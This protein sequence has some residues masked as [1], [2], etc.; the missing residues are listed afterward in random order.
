M[1]SHLNQDRYLHT[2]C[3]ATL[4]NMAARFTELHPYVCQRLVGMLGQLC[5]KLTRIK[6]RTAEIQAALQSHAEKA[7]QAPPASASAAGTA[8]ADGPDSDSAARLSAEL[9]AL[10]AERVRASLLLAP[11]SE[12]EHSKEAS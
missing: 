6:T 7:A 12:L 1:S 9:Q 8:T 3:L 11:L 4:A 10:D 5:R 2:N